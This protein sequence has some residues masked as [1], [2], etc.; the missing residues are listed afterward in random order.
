MSLNRSE[1]DVFELLGHASVDTEA[2]FS[3]AQILIV[4]DDLVDSDT[5]LLE[6]SPALADQILL[7]SDEHIADIKSG[8]TGRH[9]N[10]AFFCTS[11]TTQRMM[12]TETS[13]SLLLLPNLKIPGNPPED[14]WQVE[15]PRV[16]KCNV[17]AVKSVYLETSTI[18]APSLR[19]LK[20]VL[21]PSTFAGHIEED[22]QDVD[23]DASFYTFEHLQ[24]IVPCSPTE[25]LYAMDRLNVM[26]WNGYCR[27]FQLDYISSVLQSIFDLADE[28]ALDWPVIGFPDPSDIVTRL[29]IL[30]PPSVTRQVI[31]RFFYRKR[32]TKSEAVFPRTG[33]ICRLIGEH[34]LS[35]TRK[36]SLQDFL[37]VWCATVPH[38]M[39]PLL[40]RHL[41]SVGRAYCENSAI[42]EQETITFMPSEDLPD[43]SVEARLGA[44]FDRRKVW[45]ESELA[46]YI[47]DLVVGM[48]VDKPN[49]LPLNQR[50][51]EEL[52]V[53][54]ESEDEDENLLLDE[55][56]DPAKLA[57]DSPLPV[58]A[59]LGTLLNHCCRMSQVGGERCYMEKYPRR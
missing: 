50:A 32:H 12:E 3:H 56:K 6:I 53:L 45:P 16:T 49:C 35:V 28:Q 41:T 14:F 43:E 21:S 9:K 55:G 1:D 24:Q 31:Q 54:S 8:V 2:F 58:P 13:N 11:A 7:S 39:Q 46:G 51:E 40:R 17:A 57:L 37:S 29:E 15:K 36:F 4:N 25:L 30:Y 33:K 48:P 42:A 34:L 47:S 20:Q 44:L 52:I 26:T 10:A 22:D 38:G 5:Y 59:S 18:R 23:A 27:I 19:H